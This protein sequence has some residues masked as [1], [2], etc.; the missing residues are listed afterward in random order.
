MIAGG[1]HTLQQTAQLTRTWTQIFAL[2]TLT[3]PGVLPITMGSSAPVEFNCSSA[4][5]CLDVL[6]FATASAITF[7]AGSPAVVI[8]S[9]VKHSV[10]DGCV[11][12]DNFGNARSQGG[13]LQVQLNADFTCRGCVFTRN[14]GLG[15]GSAVSVLFGA[16]T[17]L[18]TV[19]DVSASSHAVLL[20]LTFF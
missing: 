11:F 18:N 8:S 1:V 20:D 13:G 7:T 4:V 10:F 19:F 17:F 15:D 5:T 6:A 3:A 9:G 2:S 14:S 16:A 12:A